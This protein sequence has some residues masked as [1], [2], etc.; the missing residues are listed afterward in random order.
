MTE[1]DGPPSMLCPPFLF[2]YREPQGGCEGGGTVPPVE[3]QASERLRP[4]QGRTKGHFEG[5][6]LRTASEAQTGGPRP[7]RGRERWC[8]RGGDISLGYCMKWKK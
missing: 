2:R 6:S 5:D 3:E 4:G 8:L 1:S 7:M